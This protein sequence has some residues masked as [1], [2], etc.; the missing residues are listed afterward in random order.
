VKWLTTGKNTT[1]WAMSRFTP[2]ILSLTDIVEVLDPL[3]A[4]RDHPA[5]RGN[6]AYECTATILQPG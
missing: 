6:E 3:P 1:S 2:T 4:P 5:F